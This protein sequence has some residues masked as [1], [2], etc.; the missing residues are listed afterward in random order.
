MLITALEIHIN[1]LISQMKELQ[2]PF[3]RHIAEVVLEV[4][5]E[6]R[7]PHLRVCTLVH[8]TE[9]EEEACRGSSALQ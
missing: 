9:E 8:Y 6:P 3:H 5:I 1:T 7:P 4:E 2:T